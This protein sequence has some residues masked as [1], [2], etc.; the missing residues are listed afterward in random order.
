MRTVVFIL[1]LGVVVGLAAGCTGSG[2]PPPSADFKASV[3]TGYAPVE[4]QFTDISVGI[5][6]TWEWDFD[7]DGIVDDTVPN[8]RH[9]YETPGN[10]T[11]SLTVGGPGGSSSETKEDYIVL[12]GYPCK[13]AF[14]TLN[15]VPVEGGIRV[16][17]RGDQS[18]GATG[19]SWD[20]GD[21]ETSDEM[22]PIH[23]YTGYGPYTVS[24]VVTS[25]Y[26]ED[27]VTKEDCV[28]YRPCPVADFQ[29]D[30]TSAQVPALMQFT[31]LS[32]GEITSWEWDFDGDGK[33]DSNEQ[34]PQ[35]TYAAAGLYT[36]ILEVTGPGGNDRE[37][38]SGYVTVAASPTPTPQPGI[39]IADFVANPTVGE[40]RTWVNFTD[41]STGSIT[42]WEWDLDGDGDVDATAQNPSYRYTED[43]VYSVTLTVT[44]MGCSDSETKVAYIHISGC[45]T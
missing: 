19:W 17:F 27:S 21:G 14:I 1:L 38:K 35:H 30:R 42:K 2:Q 22:N 16:A 34:N 26:C 37:I 32:S 24:L 3:T 36:V 10:Y 25:S 41:L 9:T 44:G 15:P 11:V 7:G 6:D 12:S 20:F 23:V 8:P 5:I 29:A 13:A 45:P 4:L 31:D 33:I 28:H 18:T 43:G 40:G 39:C